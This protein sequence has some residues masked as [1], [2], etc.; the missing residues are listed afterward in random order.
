MLG[1]I[2]S[3]RAEPADVYRS[4]RPP[5]CLTIM[6]A[7]PILMST[8]DLEAAGAGGFVETLLIQL[9]Y[10]IRKTLPNE[11]RSTL[12]SVGDLTRAA[13]QSGT[14]LRTAALLHGEQ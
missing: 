6:W 10:S 7:M 11:N 12:R 14:L 3:N 8:T 2:L 5:Y 4:F 1:P 13:D 9:R